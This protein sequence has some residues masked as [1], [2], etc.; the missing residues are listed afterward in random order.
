MTMTYLN[1]VYKMTEFIQNKE[2]PKYPVMAGRAEV[3]NT[4]AVNYMADIF[5]KRQWMDR[6]FNYE[7]KK[8]IN[9]ERRLILDMILAVLIDIFRDLLLLETKDDVDIKV[10][11]I[12]ELRKYFNK[13][14]KNLGNRFDLY[15]FKRISRTWMEWVY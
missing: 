12:D 5:T 13:S 2:I 3:L 9:M 6:L 1:V 4:I 10:R 11:E 14:I 7:K 15:N 8:E